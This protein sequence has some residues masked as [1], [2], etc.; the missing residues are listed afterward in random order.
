MCGGALACN[1]FSWK[2]P[3]NIYS[4]IEVPLLSRGAVRTREGFFPKKSQ[5]FFGAC[6]NL[7]RFLSPRAQWSPYYLGGYPGYFF[8]GLSTSQPDRAV[9]SAFALCSLSVV[10]T[11]LQCS[12]CIRVTF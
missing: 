4:I 6:G 12:L 1:G 11:L 2:S 9:G 7:L 8:A 3:V 10:Y 5:G